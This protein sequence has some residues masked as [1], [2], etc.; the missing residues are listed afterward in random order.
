MVGGVPRSQTSSVT[1]RERAGRPAGRR[2]YRGLG[3][4][5]G[6]SG[7]RIMTDYGWMKAVQSTITSANVFF[8]F[9]SAM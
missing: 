8:P 1:K 6:F 7:E 3:V 9:W 5:Q 2:M 4:S